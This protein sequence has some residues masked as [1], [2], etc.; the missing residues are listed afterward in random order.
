MTASST[1]GFDRTSNGPP[2]SSPTRRD[3]LG[4]VIVPWTGKTAAVSETV[5]YEWRGELTDEEVVE[6]TAAHGGTGVPGWW[7]RIRPHSLGWVVA[8]GDEGRLV[9][10]VNVAWDGGDHA[11]LLDTKTRSDH[12]RRG[13]ASEMVGLA[14]LHAKAAGCEWLHVDFEPA[15]AP[16]Y[17]DA[18]RF[19]TTDAG[20]LHLRSMT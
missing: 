2:W 6:L 1:A 15:L 13:I 10:F 14:A 7:N 5:T 20:L 19:R 18:C 11:F 16:F 8:R 9:G 4:K 17:L 12:Q 3:D